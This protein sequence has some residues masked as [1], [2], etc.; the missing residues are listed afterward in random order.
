MR[1]ILGLTSASL[2]MS[3]VEL[4]AHFGIWRM[5]P[6]AVFTHAGLGLHAPSFHNVCWWIANALTDL[7]SRQPSSHQAMKY[8]ANGK[9]VDRMDLA[10]ATYA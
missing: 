10:D 8:G 6:K 5:R 2:N 9:L 1:A 7:F 4:C 3:R